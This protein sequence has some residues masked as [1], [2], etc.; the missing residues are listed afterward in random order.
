MIGNFINIFGLDN[1]HLDRGDLWKRILVVADF[2]IFVKFY[3]KD[4]KFYCNLLFVRY[5]IIPIDN[6]DNWGSINEHKKDLIEK[7]YQENK[8]D[9]ISPKLQSRGSSPT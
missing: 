4:E 7:K 9:V 1:K 5:M 3:T 8:K 6:I 2:F